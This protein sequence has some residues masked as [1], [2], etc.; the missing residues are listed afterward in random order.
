VA[1]SRRFLEQADH[2]AIRVLHGGSQLAG[3]DVPDLLLE[4]CTSVM[5]LTG[6]ITVLIPRFMMGSFPFKYSVSSSVYPDI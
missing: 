1:P 2:V 5:S 6:S 3:A 4:L